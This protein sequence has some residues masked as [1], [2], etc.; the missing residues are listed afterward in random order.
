M[1]VFTVFLYTKQVNSYTTKNIIIFK[2]YAK[3]A[4]LYVFIVFAYFGY[5]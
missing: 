5:F 4:I 2:K 3:L 1:Y